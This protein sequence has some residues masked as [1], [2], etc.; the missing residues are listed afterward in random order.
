MRRRDN[1]NV[2][3]SHQTKKW[4]VDWL[5]DDWLIVASLLDRLHLIICALVNANWPLCLLL[6]TERFLQRTYWHG[7]QAFSRYVSFLDFFFFI[8][9]VTWVT[10]DHLA[11]H[12][13]EHLWLIWDLA[14]AITY[15]DGAQLLWLDAIFQYQMS[16]LSFQMETWMYGESNV[17]GEQCVICKVRRRWRKG[18]YIF[19]G[20]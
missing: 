17:G 16:S 6:L 4:F 10:Q 18:K 9:T 19:T 14:I 13:N 15:K 11:L 2:Q 3:D 12:H 20:G 8:T 7:P 5:V 1:V